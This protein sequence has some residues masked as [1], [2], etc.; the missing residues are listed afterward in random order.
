MLTIYDLKGM[1]L[2]L[3]TLIQ[4][5]FNFWPYETKGTKLATEIDYSCVTNTRTEAFSK[6]VSR[7][8]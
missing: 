1:L 6:G 5:P 2:V 7:R 8:E 4:K 3:N